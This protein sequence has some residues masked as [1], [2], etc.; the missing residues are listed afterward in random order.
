MFDEA[1]SS[2]LDDPGSA[3]L[4]PQ[5]PEREPFLRQLPSVQ[6]LPAQ[7]REPFI[8]SRADRPYH[9]W[10]QPD[11]ALQ[12]AMNYPGFYRGPLMPQMNDFAQLIHG[13]V[14]GLGRFGSRY[15]GMPAIAMGTYAS[16][17]WKAYQAGMHQ[18]AGD[19][20]QQY[21]QARQMTIDR[22][23]EEMLEY[24]KIYAIYFKD[25]KITDVNGFSHDLL[26]A[27]EKY[28]NQS[29]INQ[30]QSG[31]IGA[32]ER[33]LQM[34][35]SHIMNLIKAQHQEEAQRQA[36]RLRDAEIQRLEDARRR[37]EERR[38]AIERERQKYD[39]S[40]TGPG[41][42]YSPVPVP[43]ASIP[44]APSS[45]E[46]G[47]GSSEDNDGDIPDTADAEPSEP[48]E[49]QKPVQVADASGQVPTG[50]VAQA[51]AT[52]PQPAGGKG[53][54]PGGK[55]ETDA[56]ERAAKDYV[57]KRKLPPGVEK[58]VPDIAGRM[59]TRAGQLED[60]LDKLESDP[61][62]HPNDISPAIRKVFPS[63]ADKI[64][65]F[66]AGNLTPTGQR[67]DP[68]WQRA[69]ALAHRINPDFNQ[70]TF[71]S[72]QQGLAYWTRG[73]G[74]KNLTSIG[75]AYHHA[76]R[77]LDHLENKPWPFTSE[78]KRYF[79][80]TVQSELDTDIST[81]IDEYIRARS[82]KSPTIPEQK[83]EKEKFNLNYGKE[84]LKG[85]VK[86]DLQLLQGRLREQQDAFTSGTGF[87]Q[88]DILRRFKTF[89]QTDPLATNRDR[90]AVSGLEGLNSW[91]PD[92]DGKPGAGKV[93]D[94]RDYF[95]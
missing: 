59:T 62:I 11:F 66:L 91:K 20:Y 85:L 60:W 5:P 67:S 2:P 4:P 92:G 16:A 7:S 86:E 33:I 37:E 69:I 44:A 63:L 70:G 13:A 84:Y 81:F 72:R 75:T 9:Q 93:I 41:P 48:E 31:N 58:N 36:K 83:A 54:E 45:D 56:I 95:R 23:K 52:S 22:G 68:E 64:D 51:G 29:L 65:G 82:G 39:P 49:S 8:P 90:E 76:Q 17:Y 14:M 80:S 73:D 26:Q 6:N 57:F 12:G 89:T 78:I 88:Q 61:K 53:L 1:N 30:I 21:R 74:G 79:G 3:V 18:R 50:P 40:A 35:D 43:P 32:A 38:K 28:Q 94:Y 87:P 46:S 71:Q 47:G 10:G 42:D 24:A 15:T 19:A 27:A 25:G 34:T 55:P 77:L